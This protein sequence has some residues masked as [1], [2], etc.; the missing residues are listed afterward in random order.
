MNQGQKKAPPPMLPTKVPKKIIAVAIYSFDARDGT[1]ISLA[2]GESVEV[3]DQE[4]DGWWVGVNAAG[5]KGQFPSNYVE[6]R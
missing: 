1:E 2:L 3:V 4:D 6:L 5:Q